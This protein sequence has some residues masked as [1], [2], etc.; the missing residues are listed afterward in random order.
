MLFDPALFH[1]SGSPRRASTLRRW[2]RRLCLA[3]LLAVGFGAA[4]LLFA[5]LV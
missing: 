3:A 4:L 5:P 2:A 1:R